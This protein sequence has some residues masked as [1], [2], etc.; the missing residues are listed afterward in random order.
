MLAFPIADLP[1]LGRGKGVK[2]INV[3]EGDSLLDFITF[4]YNHGFIMQALA[5]AKRQRV[6]TKEDFT[7]FIAR[8]ATAGKKALHGFTNGAEFLDIELPEDANL[9]YEV[10]EELVEKA[11][12]IPTD[13]LVD[14]MGKDEEN[15][16]S[17][18][19]FAETSEKE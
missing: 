4:D 9:N 6:I 7:T 2:T 14:M 12:A 16:P 1:E 13:A 5:G 3:K 11:K 17:L 8:R 19:D 18:F 10:P 15:E